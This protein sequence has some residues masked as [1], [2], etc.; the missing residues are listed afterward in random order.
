MRITGVNELKVLS[1]AQ[2]TEVT[3]FIGIVTMDFCLGIQ[4]DSVSNGG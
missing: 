1:G 3:C 4:P 2:S